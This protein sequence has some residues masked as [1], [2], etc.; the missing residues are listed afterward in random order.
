[1]LLHATSL[2]PRHLYFGPHASLYELSWQHTAD[3]GRG[4]GFSQS[5]KKI[6]I[7]RSQYSIDERISEQENM[8]ITIMKQ[9]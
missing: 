5:V 1:M 7:T 3:T 9:I 2:A 6:I 8:Q 4:S